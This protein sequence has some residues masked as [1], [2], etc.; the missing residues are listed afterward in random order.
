MPA[1]GDNIQAVLSFAMP[2]GSI[3]QNVFYYQIFSLI[4]D[5]W[6]LVAQ[7]ILDGLVLVYADWMDE[8]ATEIQG[9]QLVISERDTGAGEWNAVA[10]IAA[11]VIFG[12]SVADTSSLFTTST[13]V[14]YPATPRNWGFKNFPPPSE[15]NTTDGQLNLTSLAPLL[16]TGA[17]W[18]AG[19][20]G[21]NGSYSP[22]VYS[23]AVELFRAFTGSIVA[24][25]K[26]GSR[27]SRKQGVGI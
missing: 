23:I 17:L 26:L 15:T 16:I 11:D 14:A 1:P 18:V 4:I 13:V 27:V 20:V 5:D 6:E 8:V 7:D 10:S 22:G 21:A 2:D 9:Q 24:G 12:T 25:T 19:I 3:M